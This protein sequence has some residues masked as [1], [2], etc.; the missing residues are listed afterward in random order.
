VHDVV[1]GAAGRDD[2]ARAAVVPGVDVMLG[3]KG[4]DALAG[5]AA[6]GLDT[7]AFGE[8]FAE[9]PVGIGLAQVVLADEGKLVQVLDALD[10]LRLHVVFVHLLTVV[11]RV[12]IG[13]ADGLYKTLALPFSDL[14]T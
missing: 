3:V 2:R 1:L 14:F 4:D 11:G 12:F 6:R 9:Q 13:V 7:D 10:V 5:G 8:G